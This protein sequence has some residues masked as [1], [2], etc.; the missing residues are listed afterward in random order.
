M[1]N[2]DALMLNGVGHHNTPAHIVDRARIV[3]GEIDLDPASNEIAQQTIRARRYYTIHD[4][5]FKHSW[6]TSALWLNPPYS[7]M[8]PGCARP[9]PCVDRWITPALYG[10]D[11]GYIIQGMFCLAARTDTR[12]FRKLWRFPMCFVFGRLHFTGNAPTFPSVIVYMPP[13]AA[14][15]D[16]FV[17]T[18]QDVGHIALPRSLTKS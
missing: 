12:W 17:D 3:M 16:R 15:V 18:F 9:T 8:R 2:V 7:E 11:H 6:R 1:T 13:D 10:Y 5:A 14:C 4:D